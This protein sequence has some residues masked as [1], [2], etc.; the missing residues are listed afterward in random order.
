MFNPDLITDL[1]GDQEIKKKIAELDGYQKECLA[2]VEDINR[3]LDSNEDLDIAKLIQ[4]SSEKCEFFSKVTKM[5]DETLKAGM[6]MTKSIYEEACIK[7]DFA[8]ATQTQSA[9]RFLIRFMRTSCKLARGYHAIALRGFDISLN[10]RADEMI[11]QLDNYR[12]LHK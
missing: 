2:E 10:D 6:H 7:D 5:A 8:E 3:W 9:C 11:Q 4:R 12:L 1:L